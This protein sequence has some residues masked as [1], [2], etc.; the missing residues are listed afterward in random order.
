MVTLL[1]DMSWLSRYD[2]RRNVNIESLFHA[3]GAKDSSKNRGI[4]QP[5]NRR[6]GA[7]TSDAVALAIPLS[8]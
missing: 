2:L 6:R 3:P 7:Q 8:E 4:I 5:E 1:K